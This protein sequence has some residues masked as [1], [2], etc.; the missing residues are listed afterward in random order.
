MAEIIAK[1]GLDHARF[2][3]GLDEA[4]R[5]WEAWAQKVRRN[6]V[7]FVPAK[8]ARESAEVFAEIERAHRQHIGNLNR[9][10][11]ERALSGGAGGIGNRS[12]KSAAESASAFSALLPPLPEM[13][14]RADGIIG[15]LRRK[16]GAA[17]VFKDALGGLGVGLGVGAFVE[18][19]VNHFR[20]GAERA[21]AMADHTEAMVDI[22]RTLAGAMGGP[23]RELELQVKAAN[24]LTRDI[25]AQKALLES[26]R[27]APLEF[28]NA[29]YEQQVDEA[30]D[31]L[32]SLV[33]KQAQLGVG[34]KMAANADKLRTEALQRQARAAES[35]FAIEM[36]NGVAAMQFDQRRK[37][38]LEEYNAQQKQGALPSAL[39]EI[40]NRIKALEH[41]RD[42]YMRNRRW[43]MEDIK[44]Q[45]DVDQELA[46]AELR[47]A[48]EV[49]KKQIR[50]NALRKEQ[51]VIRNRFG[52]NS[53]ELAANENETKRLQNGIKIDQ[54]NAARTL[55][56][57]LADIG[58]SIAGNSPNGKPK[59]RPR[60]RSEAERIADR[61]AGFVVQAE[62]AA[63][64]GRSPDYVARLTA[65]A[66]RDLT[67][68]GGKISGQTV[69]VNPADA[70][71]TGS[72]LLSTNKILTEIRDNLKPTKTNSGGAK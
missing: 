51:T 41:E 60:G 36:R 47:N 48:S 27:N 34:A 12:G 54:R 18:R 65:A 14:R 17:N 30:E 33:Q 43:Q 13:E 15:M 67:R 23:R 21:K 57:T 71:A 16:F 38:L 39:Q 61:G 53:P 59:P 6:P 2:D 8:S 4:S 40:L 52:I 37:T 66:A 72:S 29:E 44:R 56:N 55:V 69:K 68:A 32:N 45:G 50:L 10:R 7:Q 19:I 58:N 24:E 28:L 42:I 49:E 1:I 22:Q 64:T 62:E 3:R 9:D 11:L 35:M 20:H 63:R 26:L 70:T 5:G 25:E 46:D 31:K